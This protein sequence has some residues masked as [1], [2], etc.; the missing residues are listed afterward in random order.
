MVET[1]L[2]LQDNP[3]PA[4]ISGRTHVKETEASILIHNPNKKLVNSDLGTR[5]IPDR[6]FKLK[7][8]I[9]SYI[10]I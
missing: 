9:S 2:V 1:Y 3:D 5:K 8:R 6:P 7:L 10:Y 4:T